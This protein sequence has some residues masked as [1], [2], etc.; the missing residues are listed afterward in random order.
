MNTWD[1]WKPM[2]ELTIGKICR[3]AARRFPN[4]VIINAGTDEVIKFK[5][6]DERANRIANGLFSFGLKP[7]DSVA[8]L[9]GWNIRNIEMYFA[10]SK[11]GII[12]VPLSYRLNPKEITIMLNYIGTTAI[13]FEFKYKDIV[14]QISYKMRKI[15]IDGDM[16]ESINY[17]ELFK[18]DSREP[19]VEIRGDF[20][21]TVGFTSGTTGTPKCYV[22]SHYGSFM[23]HLMFAT[24]FELGHNDIGLTAIPPLTGLG[25][26]CGMMIA[27]GTPMVMDFDA[28][29][30]LQSI[31]KYKITAIHGVPAMLKSMVDAPNLKKYD[32]SSLTKIATGGA[33][34]P[35]PVLKKIWEDLC[36][37]VYD[38][39]GLQET[40]MASMI[41]PEMKRIKPAS[42][43]TPPPM[44]DVRIVDEKDNDV[45]IG[46]VGEIVIR[47]AE[48]TSAYWNNE[49][50]TKQTVKNGWFHTGD[51]GKLDDD[52][53]LYLVGRKKDM[54]ITGGYNVYAQD[55][56]EIILQLNAVSACA[57]IGLPDDRWGERVTAVV[58]LKEGH[59]LSSEDIIAF[60]QDKIAK[61]RVPKTVFIIDELPMT[62]TGKTMKFKLVEMFT[63]VQ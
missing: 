20:A 4:N 42:I 23:T 35:L 40:G 63:G 2:G 50:A 34:I 49:E 47:N 30:C 62:T 3:N 55:V 17:H 21:S 48:C 26:T 51:L 11:A 46:E 19:I 25:W 61:Y 41:T 32:L 7:G 9:T 22:R 29:K 54:I 13:I 16:E 31:E 14:D 8:V 15:V 57:V 12:M 36:P 43:G 6:L 44:H 5:D 59:I 10:C 52:R 28:E 39:Y 45:A 24:V 38:Q 27:G 33:A 58:V 56:E 18:N 60:C 1:G 53:Y 37:N